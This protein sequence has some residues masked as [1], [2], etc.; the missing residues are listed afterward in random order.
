MIRLQPNAFKTRKVS[1][2]LMLELSAREK[3]NQKL[4]A[5]EPH[6]ANMKREATKVATAEGTKKL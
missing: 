5:M 4:E 2:P 6:I 1:K 3:V